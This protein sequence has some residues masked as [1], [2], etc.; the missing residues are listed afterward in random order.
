MIVKTLHY[1]VPI[2]ISQ[3]IGAYPLSAQSQGWNNKYITMFHFR[4]FS[5]VEPVV[6]FL[7]NSN[8][9]L[10]RCWVLSN[11]SQGINCGGVAE[12]PCFSSVFALCPVITFMAEISHATSMLSLYSLSPNG[13]AHAFFS[14]L[15]GTLVSFQCVS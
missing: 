1:S 10:D 2:L 12:E 7:F 14:P 15:P 9:I 4:H 6:H 3:Q 11:L 8:V 5:F 13:A